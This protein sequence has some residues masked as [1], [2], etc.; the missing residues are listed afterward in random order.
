MS[1]ILN[2]GKQ[3][4][5]GLVVRRLNIADVMR[6]VK[7]LTKVGPRVVNLYSTNF[8]QMSEEEKRA[9][10]QE[11]GFAVLAL[12][13][14]ME[15]DIMSMLGSLVNKTPQ[16]FGELP[17]EVLLEVIN[18]VVESEDLQAF[19]QKVA[20]LFKVTQTQNQ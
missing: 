9:K 10:Q 3:I 15:D 6:V 2:Q 12:I 17:P 1:T 18:A 4:S 20:S 13:P 11:L 16:E 8:T 14:E 5:H 7:L 19:F